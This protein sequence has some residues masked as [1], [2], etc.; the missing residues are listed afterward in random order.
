[1]CV[2]SLKLT[3]LSRALFEVSEKCSLVFFG[4]LTGFLK[5]KNNVSPKISQNNR[6]TLGS[7]NICLIWPKNL[8]T[9]R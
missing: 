8:S 5:P 3:L 4:F 9:P 1:M 2:R 6:E 7:Q